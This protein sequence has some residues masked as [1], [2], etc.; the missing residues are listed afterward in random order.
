MPGV[1]GYRLKVTF[2]GARSWAK[3]AGSCLAIAGPALYPYIHKV[4]F[5]KK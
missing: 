3:G 4:N 2:P 5:S 1:R